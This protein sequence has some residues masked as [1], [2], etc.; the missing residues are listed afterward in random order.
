MFFKQD[1]Q[2]KYLKYLNPLEDSS[3]AY[4]ETET[5]PWRMAGLI[6]DSSAFALL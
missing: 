3:A 4:W 5:M 1:D 6:L 2:I